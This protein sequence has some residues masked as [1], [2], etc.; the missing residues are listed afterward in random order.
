M[1]DGGACVRQRPDFLF[2]L[3]DK[4]MVL[5]CGTISQDREAICEKNRMIDIAQALGGPP[6]C[7]RMCECQTDTDRHLDLK[8]LSPNVWKPW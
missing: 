6:T 2:D 3:L 5:E 7:I 4:Y 8:L 1:V